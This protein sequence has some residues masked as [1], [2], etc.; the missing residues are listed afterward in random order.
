MSADTAKFWHYPHPQWAVETRLTDIVKQSDTAVHECY[1]WLESCVTIVSA[2]LTHL[3]RESVVMMEGKANVGVIQKDRIVGSGPIKHLAVLLGVLLVSTASISAYADVLDKIR[4]TKTI[5]IAYR[6]ASLPFSFLD[7]NKQP[8]GYSI[9]V[10]LKIAEAVKQK[11]KLSQLT[12]A[13]VPVT[14]ATRIST[15]EAGKA[16]LEC[17][18]TTNTPERRQHVAFTIAHFIAGVRMIVNT[19][20]G[21]KNWPDLRNKKVASTKGTTSVKTLSDRGQVR[22]LNIVLSEGREHDDSFR[23]VEDKKVDAFVMDDVLLYG[24]RAASKNPAAYQVVGDALSTEPY[25]IMLPKDD[26][27]FKAL[28]DLEMARMIQDGE[29]NKLYQKWF[30]NPIAA[31]NNINL[32]MPMGY[33]LKESLRFPSDQIGN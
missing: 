7:Q 12:I 13:Y 2:V 22:S 9:D 26:P 14:S 33:L 31:K 23:M 10:C 29:L 19:D 4:D 21:I 18:S 32:K 17:G 8:V 5:T 16:D 25:A 15:I 20:S 11:L 28:V 30:L 1:R 24:L 3:L 27:A 6:D